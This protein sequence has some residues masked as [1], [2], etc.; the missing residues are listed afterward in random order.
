[1]TFGSGA[2]LGAWAKFLLSLFQLFGEAR[3]IN[4]ELPKAE[5]VLGAALEARDGVGP[6]SDELVGD[7]VA[8]GLNR[9]QEHV[10]GC[11]IC[12]S[13]RHRGGDELLVVGEQVLVAHPGTRR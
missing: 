1:M 6:S 2:R 8:G 7:V 12:G 4:Q 3:R 13:Q 9:S 5:R 11:G 10:P